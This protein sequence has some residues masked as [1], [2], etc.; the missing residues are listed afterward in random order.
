MDF[1]RR[2]DRAVIDTSFALSLHRVTKRFGSTVALD[3]ARLDVRSGTLHALLGEN[4]AGKTTLMRL[5]FGILR[6]DE[7]AIVVNGAARRW[8][9][10]ADAIA[11]GVGMVHQHFLLV[12]AMNRPCAFKPTQR[13][14]RPT[15]ST[16]KTCAPR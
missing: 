6:P 1:R 10:S 16:W 12:P 14:C 15:A 9:S 3:G 8:K 11:A 4:G 5:A 2:A 13:H 7:G